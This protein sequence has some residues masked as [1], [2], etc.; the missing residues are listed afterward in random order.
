MD[1]TIGLALCAATRRLRAAEVEQPRRDARLLLA[2]ALRLP[3][4]RLLTSPERTLDDLEAAT[5]ESLVARRAS[6]EPVSRILGRREFWG[7]SFRLSPE[8]LDPRPDSETLVEAALERLSARRPSRLLDLGTGSGCL[9][10]ALLSERPESWGLGVDLSPAAL[11]TARTNAL[12]LG[13]SRRAAFAVM[14]WTAAVVGPFDAILCNPPYVEEGA[15]L[16]FT[17]RLVPFTPDLTGWSPIGNCFRACQRCWR[18]RVG[19]CWNWGPGRRLPFRLLAG[20]QA[21]RRSRSRPICPGRHAVLR[22]RDKKTVGMRRVC[23]YLHLR[24][25]CAAPV[26]PWGQKSGRR[27]SP[28][29]PAPIPEG[30]ELGRA[31][32]HEWAVGLCGATPSTFGFMT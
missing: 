12:D 1:L 11:A 28:T 9:L 24:E 15:G 8:T 3:P 29:E 21:S 30:R 25:P 5:F 17:T 14:D 26:R 19:R 6:R 2:E 23:L 7:L 32:R 22:S 10:L 4:E 13:L 20:L 27:S 18:P 16:P 31:C